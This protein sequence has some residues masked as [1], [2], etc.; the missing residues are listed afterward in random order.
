MG[1]GEVGPLFFCGWAAR[2]K[3][4]A[5]AGLPFAQGAQGK[6]NGLTLGEWGPI[7][8]A[9]GWNPGASRFS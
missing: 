2:A 4:K 9:T 6:G 8:A 5:T 7:V 3:G 1:G